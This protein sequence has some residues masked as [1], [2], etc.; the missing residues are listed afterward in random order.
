MEQESSSNCHKEVATDGVRKAT[1]S[2]AFESSV[3][4]EHRGEPHVGERRYRKYR[5]ARSEADLDAKRR[6]TPERRPRAK[7]K[8]EAQRAE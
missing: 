4:G 5:P 1:Q 7:A 2:H 6:R 3:P 8:G